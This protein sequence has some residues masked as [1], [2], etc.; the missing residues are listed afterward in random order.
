VTLDGFIE[1]PK[2]EMDWTFANITKESR[3]HVFDML[4]TI[5]TVVMSRVIYQGFKRYRRRLLSSNPHE[6]RI[7]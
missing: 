3:E 1:G 5:D 7:D 2:G 4:S 6:T